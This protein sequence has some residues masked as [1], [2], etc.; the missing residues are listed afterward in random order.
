M[1]PAPIFSTS[2]LILPTTLVSD[3]FTEMVEDKCILAPLMLEDAAL[4]S[5]LREAKSVCTARLS[6]S[7][8]TCRQPE[9]ESSV[10]YHPSK[11]DL[12]AD[13]IRDREGCRNGG[14]SAQAD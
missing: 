9:V 13:S 10:A 2:V 11:H 1:F 12:Y 3:A 7:S 8:L 14:G 5:K 4:A 6:S